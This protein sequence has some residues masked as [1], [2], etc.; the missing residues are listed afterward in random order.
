M[1][2]AL[3]SSPSC[4]I[5]WAWQYTPVIPGCSGGQGYPQLHSELVQG[6]GN[7]GPCLKKTQITECLWSSISSLTVVSGQASMLPPS[8]LGSFLQGSMQS[9]TRHLSA[10]LWLFL[11]QI[12]HFPQSRDPSRECLLTGLAARSTTAQPTV[13]QTLGFWVLGAESLLHPCVL[14]GS[15]TLLEAPHVP[16]G[17]SA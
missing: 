6:Q 13:K 7:M 4:G 1:P 15:R 16:R 10:F 5:N 3:G 17:L 2:K 8:M 11:D 12:L 14:P 9:R